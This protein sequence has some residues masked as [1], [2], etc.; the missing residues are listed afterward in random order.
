[1]RVIGLTGGIGS[2]KSTAA[3]IL[4]DLG[5][6]VIH[7]DQVGHEV[8]E[9]GTT[10]WQLVV[11]AFG[12]EILDT[13]GRIDRQKLGSIV[14]AAPAALQRLNAIVHPLIQQSIAQRLAALHAGGG[15]QPIVIEAAILIEANWQSLADEVWLVVAPKG[16]VV[17]RLHAQRQMSAPQVEARIRTQLS[18][19]ERRRHADV[20]IENTGSIDDLR[21]RLQQE[22]QRFCSKS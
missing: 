21:C 20:I 19:A 22:W 15:Q 5:A 13:N 18:D 4:G 1:M 2:G 7:A 16:D 14:F 11:D 6:Q 9:P 8:Y 12:P 10:G 17:Q 3:A